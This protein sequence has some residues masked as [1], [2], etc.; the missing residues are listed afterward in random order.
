MTS[1]DIITLIGVLITFPVCFINLL[2]NFGLAKKQRYINT[3]TQMRA[4]YLK[5]L[6]EY[7]AIFLSEC[8][9]I[10]TIR[11]NNSVIDYSK[12]HEYFDLILLCLSEDDK[13][14]NGFQDLLNEVYLAIQ[15]KNVINVTDKMEE[16]I[17][18]A[19]KLLNTEW[20]GIKY[21]A[22]HG[23][24]ISNKDRNNFLNKYLYKKNDTKKKPNFVRKYKIIKH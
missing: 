5:Q 24:G 16:M 20:Q 23:N 12:L 6:R 9:N 4:E 13:F 2:M 17:Y 22:I 7:I 15:D 21:E 11:K 18:Q 19:R 14:D 1:N 3:I 8:Q 10:I